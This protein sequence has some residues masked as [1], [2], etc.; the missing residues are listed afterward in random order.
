M[1]VAARR[2]RGVR[3]RRNPRMLFCYHSRV[4]NSL[5]ETSMK[6]FL[7]ALTVALNGCSGNKEPDA[8]A[9]P[10]DA[11]TETGAAPSDS[12]EPAAETGQPD[13]GTPA[14]D[15]GGDGDTGT[16]PVDTDGDGILDS[17]EGDDDPDGDG[18]PNR[19]DDDSDGDTIPDAIEGDVDTD[20]DGTADYLD[21]DSDADGVPDATEGAE[22]TD[23]DG[24]ADYLDGDDDGDGFSE[25][26]GDCNDG[27]DTIFPGAPETIDGVDESCDGR[28]DDG[29]TAFDDDG[30]GVSE[31]DGDC[32]DG[33]ALAFPGATGFH[34]VDR[35][36]GSFDYN[37][38][39]ETTPSIGV[40]SCLFTP[41]G[42]D[43]LGCDVLSPGTSFDGPTGCGASVT[44]YNSCIGGAP[45]SICLASCTPAGPGTPSTCTTAVQSCR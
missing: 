24:V 26:D 1:G 42:T 45:A 6:M 31:D 27:D 28:I 17:I 19:L 10:G 33:N 20:S 13:T 21:T 35:G 30:D 40:F 14:A 11:P 29:T 34:A 37:C 8:P 7:F 3:I 44:V 23:G 41:A 38:D 15:T 36:D 4:S 43:G 32:F 2:G 22:D 16:G 5:W 12:G 25:A 39:G 18:I 9:E